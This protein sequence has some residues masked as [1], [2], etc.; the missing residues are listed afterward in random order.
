MKP[1]GFGLFI[2]GYALLYSG[3]SNLFTGGNGWGFMQSLLNK[4]E[5]NN[6]LSGISSLFGGGSIT[7]AVSQAAIDAA[8]A[9]AKQ[10]ASPF[11][12]VNGP[13]GTPFTT[14]VWNNFKNLWGF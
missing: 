6:D 13:P 2:V 3:A 1:V 5:G 9:L 12:P 7:G 8:K 11:I 4:G 14:K 10:Q